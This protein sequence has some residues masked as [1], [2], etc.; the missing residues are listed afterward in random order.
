MFFP[1][2]TKI[3]GAS[4]RR[5][6]PL[7]NS[8]LIAANV[9]FFILGFSWSWGVGGGNSIITI[10]TYS[11]VHADIFHLVTNMWV[12]WLFGNVVNERIGSWYYLI[13]YF[14]ISIG[15]GCS[16]WLFSNGL[17]VGSSGA[18]FG[19]V[20]ISTLL[21]P[22]TRIRFCYVALFPITLLIGLINRPRHW[23]EWILRWGNFS[24]M[25]L[26]AIFLVP[27]IEM[28]GLWRW[29]MIGHLNWTHLG[30]LFGFLFGI[31]AV[32]LLPKHVSMKKS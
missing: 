22:G 15:L 31:V 23:L 26:F 30:H 6:P 19:I 21:L 32:L 3:I 11:F 20:A 9:L 5:V 12:L 13:C 4:K 29:S 8:L 1:I 10:L 24:F 18:I 14:G 2:P 17:L 7:S 16:A 27:I 25:T 28:W